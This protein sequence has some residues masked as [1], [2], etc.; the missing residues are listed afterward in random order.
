MRRRSERYMNRDEVRIGEQVCKIG[1]IG[2]SRRFRRALRIA[3]R[4]ED[5]HSESRASSR[6]GAPDLTPSDDPQRRAIDV[7]AQHY[8]GRPCAPSSVAHEAVALGHT[9]GSRHQERE[10]QIGSRL[11]ENS[12]CMPD[13]DTG[14]RSS[15]EI[16]IVDADGEIADYQKTRRTRERFGVE[17][18]AH[19][20]QDAVDFVQTRDEFAVRR[21]HLVGPDFDLCRGAQPF[22]GRFRDP[23]RNE[24]TFFAGG[25]STSSVL[26]APA[27]QAP[28]LKPFEKGFTLPKL[29]PS[30]CGLRPVN[31]GDRKEL[32]TAVSALLFFGFLFRC[33]SVQQILDLCYTP[34]LWKKLRLSK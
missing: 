25:H 26:S 14:V 31:T 2:A 16:D 17:A 15:R 9:A 24:D 20:A 6:D 33:L 19:H 32:S 7:L 29:S 28:G 10:R 18:V 34:E 1:V 8:P 30:G 21:R 13:R 22:E 27:L 12:R 4:V 11:G 23:P 5:A 3:R